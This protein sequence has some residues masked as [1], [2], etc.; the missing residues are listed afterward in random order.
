MHCGHHLAALAGFVPHAGVQEADAPDQLSCNGQGMHIR[1]HVLAWDILAIH[2]SRE[3]GV[4]QVLPL[5]AG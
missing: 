1:N 4:L 5:C 2:P 3:V